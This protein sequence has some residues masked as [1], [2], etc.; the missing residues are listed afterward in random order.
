MCNIEENGQ[1]METPFTPLHR[2][3]F[4]ISGDRSVTRSPS[5]RPFLCPPSSLLSPGLV[6]LRTSTSSFRPASSL[7]FLCPSSLT[8]NPTKKSKRDR[9]LRNFPTAISNNH[10]VLFS[11]IIDLQSHPLPPARTRNLLHSIPRRRRPQLE[12]HQCRASLVCT[13]T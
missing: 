9:P 7:K 4:G 6:F 8:R 3:A 11:C 2:R 5:Y 13:E 1:S 10:P 12:I